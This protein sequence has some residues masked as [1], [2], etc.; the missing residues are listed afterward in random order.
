MKLKIVL[1][2]V[3]LSGFAGSASAQFVESKKQKFAVVP[4]EQVLLAVMPQPDCPIQFEKVRFL[5]SV[6]GGGAGISFVV[7]NVGSKSIREFTVGGADWTMNWSEKFTK[8]LLLPGE[9]AFD[10]NKEIEI[11]PLTDDLRARLKLKGPMRAILVV[12][13][14]DVEYSD[15]T[16]YSVRDVY[17]ALKQYSENLSTGK[18]NLK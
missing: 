2:I 13:V 17:K 18:L 11:V 14:I 9:T 6:D 10:R 5:A 16:S 4:P 12:M 15:G 1:L 8:K 3:T 7:R